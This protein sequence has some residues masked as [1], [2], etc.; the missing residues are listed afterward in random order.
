MIDRHLKLFKS[1]NNQSV[2]YLLI[3]GALA[4]AYGVPRVTKDIDL[5]LRPTPENAGRLL[6]TLKQIGMGTAELTTPEDICK[7]EITIF[8]DFIR[9]DVLTRVKG[10]DFDAAWKKRKILHLDKVEIPALTLEDLVVS[11]KAS[12]RKGDLEDVKILEMAQVSKKK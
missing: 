7:N 2:E 4:I 3:G 1:L 12:G 10:L 5:F 8:K 9:L 6:K 11:K